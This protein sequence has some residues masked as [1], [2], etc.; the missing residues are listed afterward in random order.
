MQLVE[1][2]F[3]RADPNASST[4][5]FYKIL[6]SCYLRARYCDIQ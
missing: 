6:G 5:L 3:S 4:A 1:E 2:I